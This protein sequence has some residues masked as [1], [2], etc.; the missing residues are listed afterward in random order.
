MVNLV[1]DAE[2][3]LV[4][5]LSDT[6]RRRTIEIADHAVNPKGALGEGTEFLMGLEESERQSMYNNDN[7]ALPFTVRD[8]VV[9]KGKR[10]EFIADHEGC[11]RGI[12]VFRAAHDSTKA[13]KS[14]R[15]EKK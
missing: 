5:T 14:W 8:N 10:K 15:Q 7:G 3:E 6:F 11:L 4:D 1:E 2:D 13:M 9:S 12:V